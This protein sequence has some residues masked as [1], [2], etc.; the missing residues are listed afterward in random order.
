MLLPI[1]PRPCRLA[2][3]MSLCL[4]S[5][6]LLAATEAPSESAAPRRTELEKV[7]VQG[8]QERYRAEQ[9][10]AST[11]TPTPLLDT[12]Q[13]VTVITQAQIRDQAM[14]GVADSL[15][16]VPG[17][18]VAQGEGNRDTPIFRGS[19]STADLFVDG[20]RDDVQYFRDLYNIERVEVL[21]GPNAMVF[22]RG[23][24]GGVLNRVS[25]Q[26]E[27]QD[28]R[29]LR[30]L[31]GSWDKARASADLGGA[32]ND[33][34]AL[35]VN[36][37]AEESGS[38]RDGVESSRRGIAPV[39]GLRLG[40]STQLDLGVEHFEDK[41]TADRG[42]T[43]YLG[44][45]LKVDPSTFFGDPDRS[46][47][48]AEVDAFSALL[49]H[50]FANGLNLRNRTRIARYDKFYQNVYP[51]AYRASDDTVAISAYSNATRR[52]NLLNQ[53][54][55]T[56]Q[57]D[58]GSVRHTI[59][60]GLE[61]GRQGTDN[62]RETGYF[63]GGGGCSTV[64]T[65]TSVR[66]SLADTIYTGPICFRQSA[67]DADN[68][69]MARN[70]AVY[71]QDQIE[72]S[73]RWQAVLGLRQERLRVNLH[74][75]RNGPEL[76]TSDDLLSPRVGLVFKPRP[77]MSLYASYGEAFQ[78]RSGEQLASLSVSNATLAPEHFR[79][80]EFGFK[81]DLR[82]DLSM[83]AAAYRLARGNVAVVDPAN[84]SLLVLLEGDAQRVDGFELGISGKLTAGWSVV[85]GLAWQ[86]AQLTRDIQASASSV[87]IP[88]GSVLAQ[89][90][91]RSF[92]LWNRYDF[93]PRWGAG[94]GLV[95]RSGMYAAMPNSVLLPGYA[96]VD[97][98]VYFKSSERFQWQLN[99]ENLLD[100]EYALSA[101]SDTNISPGSPRAV[102]LSL[103]L[104]F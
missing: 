32:I 96:R 81:W 90:P 66:V 104:E 49:E 11:K 52:E 71:L 10:R 61:V 31:L 70:V 92:S 68:H 59:L 50:D 84:N 45:P 30:L 13:S 69:S 60:A 9:S 76:T 46:R 85:G 54:D 24:S 42:I 17:A 12:P 48:E 58:A 39:F 97:V 1:L 55:L 16:Y 21:K 57:L 83:T 40:N 62:F 5:P 79:N 51:G 2:L 22:G 47:S 102:S 88:A 78:P 100:R 38:F 34:M 37:L 53:T 27:W 19:S 74:N 8:E 95:A 80:V 33:T 67:S 6:A 56:W 14:Q 23:G 25:K 26:A 94:L 64:S 44:R 35:R 98:A 86:D 82:P 72:F 41:R 77:Q 18:G 15:R 3:A 101:N 7:Q 91:R 99:L 20:I 4:P 89:V 63:P 103:N 36:A 65:S 87:N 29:E 75:N 93:N 28:H 73:P 43:S